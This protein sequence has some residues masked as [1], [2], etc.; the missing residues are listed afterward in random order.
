MKTRVY[1]ETS[2]ISYFAAK[3]ARDIIL[4]SHQASTRNLWDRLGEF[5]VYISELVIS[6][7]AKGDPEAARLRLGALADFD[8]LM[9][10]DDAKELARVLVSGSAVPESY[11]EDALH[12]AVA[13]VNGMHVVVT[14]N[15]KH[16]N[17]PFTRMMA[18]QIIEG[19]GYACP[20]ICSPDELLGDYR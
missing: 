7:A 6:E 19:N 9:I 15:F 5:D 2:V 4:A 20:E 11:P 12:L 10:D 14:W 17:N 13:A 16:L 3:P 1:M 8:E 18:R